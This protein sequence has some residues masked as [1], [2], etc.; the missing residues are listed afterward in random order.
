MQ[1]RRPR[2]LFFSMQLLS[3]ALHDLLSD[4]NYQA[5]SMLATT[6]GHAGGGALSRHLKTGVLLTESKGHPTTRQPDEG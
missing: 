1:P 2:E 5:Y 3:Q 6:A 4:K